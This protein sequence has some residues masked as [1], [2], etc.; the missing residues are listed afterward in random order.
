MKLLRLAVATASFTLRTFLLLLATARV[1][2]RLS[3][4]RSL[5]KRTGSKEMSVKVTIDKFES[6][7]V[8]LLPIQSRTNLRIVA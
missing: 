7:T 2:F 8:W 1:F 3:A 4:P 5:Q 6:L